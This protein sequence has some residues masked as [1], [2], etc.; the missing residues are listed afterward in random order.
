[1][2]SFTIYEIL[3]RIGWAA[4]L[5]LPVCLAALLLCRIDSIHPGV[6]VWILRIAGIKVTADLVLGSA[7][8]LRLLPTGSLE[9]GAHVGVGATI[10]SLVPAFLVSAWGYWVA[11]RL[12]RLA[13]SAWEAR[14]ITREAR[15]S[16]NHGLGFG[17]LRIEFSGLLACPAAV[18]LLRPRIL[19]PANENV[20]DR[21]EV[22][23]EAA[24]IRHGDLWAQLGFALLTAVLGFVP[25]VAR[26][27]RESALWQEAWADNSARRETG[28][29]ESEHAERILQRMAQP[30]PAW[31]ASM[32]GTQAG[33]ARRLKALF[34]P[35]HSLWAALAAVLMV[36]LLTVPLKAAAPASAEDAMAV[37]PVRMRAG[38]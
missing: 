25:W 7:Y 29:P 33:V 11:W 9:P 23:H 1:M 34:V 15:P 10:P 3:Y 19:L 17:S 20:I 8:G 4:L 31:T 35:K 21:T 5:A 13:G 37:S 24:H 27:E 14:Q 32:S 30:S 26:L 18:G 22:A 38:G 16:L 36:G 2:I 28:A 6:K 12:V